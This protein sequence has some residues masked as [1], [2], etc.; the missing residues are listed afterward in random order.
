MNFLLIEALERFYNFY[1]PDYKVEFPTGSGNMI[2]LDEA[3]NELTK[4][5]TKVS[6]SAFIYVAIILL[7]R[8]DLLT[9]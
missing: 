8:S 9:R 2:T 5:L 4:R 3:S 1:G 6:K 7:T